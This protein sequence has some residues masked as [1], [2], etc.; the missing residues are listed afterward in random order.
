[1][2]SDFWWKKS[3]D[4]LT[5][6]FW[7]FKKRI[8][9]YSL[10]Q[11]LFFSSEIWQHFAFTFCRYL[12]QNKRAFTFCRYCPPIV[13]CP[14]IWMTK[15]NSKIEGNTMGL[16]RRSFFP[17]NA[18]GMPSFNNSAPWF[19]KIKVLQN[20]GLLQT[21]S[22]A[23]LD[24][25]PRSPLWKKLGLYHKPEK[26]SRGQTGKKSRFAGPK[27]FQMLWCIFEGRINRLQPSQPFLNPCM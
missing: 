7:S 2:P 21:F 5:N 17:F 14:Q 18:L 16:L 20:Q 23:N 27:I 9:K 25:F 26:K 1:M 4:P 6:N 19:L 11:N 13:F 10:E 22:P 24:F 15:M 12:N 3:F 8:K